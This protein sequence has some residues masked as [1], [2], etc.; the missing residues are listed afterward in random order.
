R[1]R[2]TKCRWGLLTLLSCER[3]LM[4][5]ENWVYRIESYRW[6]GLGSWNK[7]S[8]AEANTW[9]LFG[10]KGENRSVFGLFSSRAGAEDAAEKLAT[11]R[12]GEEYKGIMANPGEKNPLLER[13]HDA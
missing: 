9:F 2:E 5:T 13:L 3:P 10:E 8:E 1:G 4:E 12:M 11:S 7:S 6:E